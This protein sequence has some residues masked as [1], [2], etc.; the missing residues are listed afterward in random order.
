MKGTARWR[1]GKTGLVH[2]L[3]AKPVISEGRPQL[4]QGTN[5]SWYAAPVKEVIATLWEPAC[6][7]R[8]QKNQR[9]GK[10]EGPVTCLACI[11]GDL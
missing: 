3:R 5:G 1:C 4:M 9:V 11:G 2:Q 10:H 6:G 7:A 8:R